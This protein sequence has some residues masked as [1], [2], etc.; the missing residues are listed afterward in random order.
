MNNVLFYVKYTKYNK[1]TKK[2][3]DRQLYRDHTDLYNRIFC[4]ETVILPFC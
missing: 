2:K 1:M 3:K 4:D